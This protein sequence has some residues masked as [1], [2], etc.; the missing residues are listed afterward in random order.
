MPGAGTRPPSGTSD[1]FLRGATVSCYHIDLVPL[2]LG[3]PV[4]GW[5]I[6]RSDRVY[7]VTSSSKVW[8]PGRTSQVFQIPEKM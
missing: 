4:I 6:G 2:D 7:S 5:T 8:V 1:E 3:T